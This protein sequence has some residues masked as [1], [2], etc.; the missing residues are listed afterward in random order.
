VFKEP[1]AAVIAK[2]NTM[3]TLALKLLD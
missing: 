3:P 2:A 1:G